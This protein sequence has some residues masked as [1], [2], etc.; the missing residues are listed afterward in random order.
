MKYTAKFNQSLTAITLLFVSFVILQA[1]KK[2]QIQQ[3]SSIS[4]ESR[5][6]QIGI[7]WRPVNKCIVAKTAKR[8][9]E[10]DCLKGNVHIVQSEFAGL[11]KKDGQ[12]VK[13]SVSQ[14]RTI[15][16]DRQ[17]NKTE[18][19][20]YGFDYN[21]NKKVD[22]RVVYNFNSKGIA[23]GWE[24]YADGRP[25]PTK[26]VYTLDNKGNRIKQI[27]T[28]ASGFVRAILT[29]IYDSKGNNVEKIYDDKAPTIS[30]FKDI[31]EYDQNKL[32]QTISYNKAG[33]ITNKTIL[34]YE[35]G[36]IKEGIGYAIDGNN[37]LIRVNRNSYRYDA[38]GNMIERI[39]YNKDDSIQ[40]KYIYGYD[41]KGNIISIIVYGS[42]GKLLGKVSITLEFD[43]QGN[44]IKHIY[45]YS[46]GAEGTDSR[47]SHSIESRTITY[48]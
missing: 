35:N 25:I 15:T 14:E 9:R 12:Y 41:E 42:D 11:V 30:R 45:N 48:Y 28:E 37:E 31:Y 13:D 8:D 18:S 38:A 29:L 27:V 21:R 43:S 36:N 24:D 4:I 47:E 7:D 17:G 1:Q 44:W 39:I 23:T 2:I 10:F 5:E 6:N 19:L 32:I 22:S 16:Y 26:S 33:L 46:N 3:N 34:T 20:V 40:I